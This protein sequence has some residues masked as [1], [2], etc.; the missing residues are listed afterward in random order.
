MDFCSLDA[1][2]GDNFRDVCKAL[3]DTTVNIRKAGK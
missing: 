1:K 2:W 3:S